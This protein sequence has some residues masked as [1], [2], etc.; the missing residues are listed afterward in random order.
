MM[1]K[2]IALVLIAILL[3]TGCQTNGGQSAAGDATEPTATYDW[4]AGES[5]VTPER[6][7]L[8]RAGTNNT[9]Y[10]IAPNGVYFMYET[11]RATSTGEKIS[12]VLCPRHES[13]TRWTAGRRV[14]PPD[15]CIPK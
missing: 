3:L 6:M 9:D 8:K 7:G 12:F 4:M 1:K 10:V 15:R 2:M 13:R 5:P 11:G 14:H